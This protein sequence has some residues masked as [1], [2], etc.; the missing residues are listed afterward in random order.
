MKRAVKKTSGGQ[1]AAIVPAAA[2]A[3]MI[4]W[5]GKVITMDPQ[6]PAAAAVA[7]KNGRFL[8]IGG[9]S[10]VRALAG[11]NTIMID[12][13]GRT[14]TPGFIDSHQHMSQY[15]TDLLQIDCS[16]GRCKGIPRIQEAVRNET[17]RKAPGE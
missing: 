5:G 7:V 12:L 16:P 8:E 3:D 1:A 13:R 11:R 15:G 9:D 4:L 17:K 2:A 14:V 10:E 6:K